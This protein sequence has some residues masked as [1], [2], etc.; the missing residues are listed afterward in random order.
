VHH[1]PG[2]IY[3]LNAGRDH[4]LGMLLDYSAGALPLILA[5]VPAEVIVYFYVFEAVMGL[6]QHANVR[7]EMGWFDYVFSSA[8]LH[9][10]HHSDVLAE[11]N[12]NYGSSLI[13]WD[14][15]FGTFYRPATR[16]QGPD[17]IGL[18]EMHVFPQRFFASWTVPFRW[19][20]LK[21]ENAAKT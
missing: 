11:A 1:S 9:R 2:R 8:H 13:V 20:A 17:R 10:W 21:R 14:L 6:V 18:A 7:H 12:S 5:G 3:W 16:P 15:V 4:P 19:A